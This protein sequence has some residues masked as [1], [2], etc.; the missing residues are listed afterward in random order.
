MSRAP[1]DSDIGGGVAEW[2][3]V[4]AL[5]T[6]ADGIQDGKYGRH[7]A[8][9][10]PS[11]AARLGRGIY[12]DTMAIVRENWSDAKGRKIDSR[13]RWGGNAKRPWASNGGA[14]KSITVSRR[15]LYLEDGVA[16]RVLVGPYGICAI[17]MAPNH[18]QRQPI[19]R[20]RIGSGE[21]TGPYA[22]LNI[23]TQTIGG[24]DGRNHG[25][26]RS[27]RRRIMDQLAFQVRHMG[28]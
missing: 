8:A 16:N 9:N 10:H 17:L 28:I 27:D 14:W 26:R 18:A 12:Y 20:L 2:D 19:L 11:L 6:G 21:K 23:L 7:L 22:T 4:S 13:K 25:R 15:R 5:E 1:E 24:V 3:R